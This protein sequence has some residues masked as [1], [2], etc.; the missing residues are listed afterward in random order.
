MKKRLKIRN[1][2]VLFLAECGEIRPVLVKKV[3]IRVDAS[4]I[5][6]DDAHGKTY[7]R[8]YYTDD[9]LELFDNYHD[10]RKYWEKH[11][12]DTMNS[13]IKKLKGVDSEISLL[14]KYRESLMVEL[15][16]IY[17]SC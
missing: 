6:M 1:G 5:T 2:D 16:K 8:V 14:N 12:L 9:V 3:D 10:A 4:F 15:E 17:R 11:N 7:E 13:I